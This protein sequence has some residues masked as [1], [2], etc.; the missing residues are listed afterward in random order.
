MKSWWWPKS[1]YETHFTPAPQSIP[2]FDFN[3]ELYPHPNPYFSILSKIILS[4]IILSQIIR[5]KFIRFKSSSS[6]HPLPRNVLHR[7]RLHLTSA[8]FSR[9]QLND[10]IFRYP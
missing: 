2:S 9:A 10:A 6:N 5:F 1:V 3:P 4:Q 8:L 7:S